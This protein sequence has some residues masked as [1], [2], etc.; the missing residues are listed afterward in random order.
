MEV[1]EGMGQSKAAMKAK[2]DGIWRQRK[3][4]DKARLKQRERKHKTVNRQEGG[5][6]ATGRGYRR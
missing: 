3:G 2:G 5:G 4:S 1:E 6:K